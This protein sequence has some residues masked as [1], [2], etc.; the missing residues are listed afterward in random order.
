MVEL[1][2]PHGNKFVEVEAEPAV[3]GIAEMGDVVDLRRRCGERAAQHFFETGAVDTR[4]QPVRAHVFGFGGVVLARVAHGER[5]GKGLAEAG[6]EPVGIVF[7]RAL[8]RVALFEKIGDDLDDGFFRQPMH[9]EL[10]GMR[11]PVAFPV[12]IQR[13]G[14][15]LVAPTD[16]LREEFL[17]A[18]VFGKGDMRPDVKEEAA[19]VAKRHGVAAVVRVLVVHD[20]RDTLLMQ[21]VGGSKAGHTASKDDDVRRRHYENSLR[22]SC[23]S[24]SLS[25][26]EGVFPQ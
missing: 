8:R 18:G 24:V 19:F 12:V 5:L 16:A 11:R 14:N 3:A 22:G 10:D 20:G 21:P 6:I 13:N 1:D 7:D 26:G 17:D 25:W 4:P 9:V 2:I 15:G 23:C